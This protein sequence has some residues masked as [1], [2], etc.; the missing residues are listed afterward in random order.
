MN[1]I[2]P[3]FIAYCATLV[4]H[5]FDSYTDAEKEKVIPRIFQEFVAQMGS[6][7]IDFQAP[8]LE[9]SPEA[10]RKLERILR[11]TVVAK[12]SDQAPV[13]P[14]DPAM[15]A[16]ISM[17]LGNPN[18]KDHLP[19]IRDLGSLLNA[20]LFKKD[21]EVSRTVIDWLQARLERA[22]LE[23]KSDGMREVYIR[24]LLAYL[25][26]FG[27]EEGT[28]LMIPMGPEGKMIHYHVERL[29]LT[30]YVLGSPLVAYGLIPQE[31]NAPPILIFKGSTY[32]ADEGNYLSLL[33]DVNPFAPVGGYAFH[34]SAKDRIQA[35]L[36]K[37]VP[38]DS[39][40]E[41]M[42]AEIMGASLGGAL[43][44][45][46]AS[47]FPKYIAK[48]S[49]FNSPAMTSSEVG[50][51]DLRKAE[52]EEGQVPRVNVYLQDGDP[53]ANFVGCCWAPDWNI[54]HVHSL[55]SEAYQAH[56]SA[57]TAHEE[58][59]IIPGDSETDNNKTGRKVWFYMQNFLMIPIF[60]LVLAFF[61]I[62]FIVHNIVRLAK[63]IFC[64][65]DD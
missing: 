50:E 30:P 36:E 6:D 63:C 55:V 11:G 28:I 58:A 27:P 45:L 64:C 29:E 51:W 19:P 24:N 20:V 26:F 2:S 8:K 25:P 57:Y 17:L 59:Y 32:P 16:I 60:L 4:P 31:E 65:S 62:L 1:P 40:E 47:Y 23:V 14:E 56:A 54:F 34:F 13:L 12:P 7:Q 22:H 18:W 48:V 37:N 49:A 39:Q 52:L 53:I 3:E 9:F 35:W 41:E 15:A 5:I 38:K 44:L 10:N 42:K 33:T 43:S 21:P 61:P 46:T